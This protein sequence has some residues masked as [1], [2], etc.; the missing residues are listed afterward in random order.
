MA[1]APAAAPPHY[2]HRISK[3]QQRHNE[4]NKKKNGNRRR[5]LFL[6]GIILVI[7]RTIQYY[8]IA[9]VVYYL[10]K[11]PTNTYD[12]ISDP[13]PD[14]ISGQQQQ[15]SKEETT[16]NWYDGDVVVEEEVDKEWE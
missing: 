7:G 6:V 15:Q 14:S 4:K 10:I 13:I 3:L 5:W 2:W 9:P 11:S 1:P 8:S 12:A 16:S